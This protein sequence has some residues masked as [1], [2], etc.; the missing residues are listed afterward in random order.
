M[1]NNNSVYHVKQIAIRS[2]KR[3][4]ILNT[5]RGFRSATP[6]HI[7][8]KRNTFILTEALQNIIKIRFLFN[9]CRFVSNA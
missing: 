4:D 1:Q 6:T 5:K 7:K 2:I 9:F 8:E 3:N